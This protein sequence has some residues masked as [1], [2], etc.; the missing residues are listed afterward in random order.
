MLYSVGPIVNDTVL[1]T[2][3]LFKEV[4]VILSVLVTIEQ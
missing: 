4:D 1:Q 2:S 3:N